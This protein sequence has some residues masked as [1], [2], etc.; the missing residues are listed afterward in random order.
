MKPIALLREYL[1]ACRRVRA[2]PS[3]DGFKKLEYLRFIGANA[4]PTSGEEAALDSYSC[5]RDA[6]GKVLERYT[7]AA[8]GADFSFPPDPVH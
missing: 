4:C 8:C 5:V 6:D 2:S 3:P 1:R 7:C